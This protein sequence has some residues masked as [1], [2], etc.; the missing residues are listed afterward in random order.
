MNSTR[1]LIVEDEVLIVETVKK[2]LL[3]KGYSNFQFARSY[4]KAIEVFESFSPD[5]VILDIRLD[6]QKS[7]LE[8]AKYLR[9]KNKSLPIVYLSSNVNDRN[10]DSA[11]SSRAAGFLSKPV[12][13]ESLWATV[14]IALFNAN[15]V[16]KDESTYTF[17]EGDKK[18]VVPIKDILFIK[19]DHIY[20]EVYLIDKKIIR[21]RS[22]FKKL[23]EQLPTDHF[24][25]T[26]RSFVANIVNASSWNG[27]QIFFGNEAV[28]IS[29][30]RKAE[31][32][33]QL[34]DV[35]R[36]N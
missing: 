30:G 14:E 27:E 22:S 7:G 32:I 34:E 2:Y 10:L 20:L 3:E 1:I 15:Q 16:K 12:R 17:I 21:I 9:Q 18:H 4:D 31:V 28:P 13:K 6:G 23:L 29:R 11:K 26:H 5:L 25:Q 33:N 35:F 19:S 36:S 8:V 24:L